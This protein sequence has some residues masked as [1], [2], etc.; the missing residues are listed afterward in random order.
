[1]TEAHIIITTPKETHTIYIYGLEAESFWLRYKDDTLPRIQFDFMKKRNIQLTSCL[2]YLQHYGIHAYQL[3]FH[4]TRFS[5]SQALRLR[6]VI[7]SIPTLNV[8]EFKNV[9]FIDASVS[10]VF[11]GISDECSVKTLIFDT[12]KMNLYQKRV[13]NRFVEANNVEHIT[14]HE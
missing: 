2:K 1:M 4:N 12:S 5:S 9:T 13:V 3:A 7:I 10:D 8:L 6:D 14:T 11:E